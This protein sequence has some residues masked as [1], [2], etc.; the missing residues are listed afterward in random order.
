MEGTNHE[1][2][3][4]VQAWA[5]ANYRTL[6]DHVLIRLIDGRIVRLP[7]PYVLPVVSLAA[8]ESQPPPQTPAKA[9]KPKTP[10]TSAGG[11]P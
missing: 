10:A 6:P 11:E 2:F 8:I 9:S 1:L 5:V 4:A 3:A 7:V